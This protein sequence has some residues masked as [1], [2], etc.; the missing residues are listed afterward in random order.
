MKVN[1]IDHICIAVKSLEE[2]RS[3]QP[4][5]EVEKFIE[6][7]GE[8]IMLISLNVDKTKDCYDELVESGNYQMID[9]P[10]PFRDKYEY[11]FVHPRSANG[12]LLELIDYDWPEFGGR[13]GFP[14][15]SAR[16]KSAH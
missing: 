7:Q 8:G 13:D 1:R 16:R 6:R 15:A 5:S 2:G 3:T 10:R 14:P 11:C 9:K 4:G 12:V